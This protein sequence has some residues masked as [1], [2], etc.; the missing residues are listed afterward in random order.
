MAEIM[1][2]FYIWKTPVTLWASKDPEGRRVY[3]VTRDRG[4]V[5]VEPQGGWRLSREMA[6]YDARHRY[7]LAAR[8]RQRFT[9]PGSRRRQR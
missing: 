9:E 1:N 3:A 6:M 7:G 5:A 2:R 4:G 8:P